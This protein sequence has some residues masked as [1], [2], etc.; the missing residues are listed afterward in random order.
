ML[1]YNILRYNLNMNFRLQNI[2]KKEKKTHFEEVLIRDNFYQTS[3][4]FPMPVTLI[5]TISDSGQTNIGAYSL[6]FPHIISGKHA[7]ILISRGSSNTAQNILKRKTVA[8][9]FIPDDKKYMRNCVEL[10]YPGESTE[11]KMKHSI[12]TLIPCFREAENEVFPQVVKEAIQI[13]ECR[14]DDSFPY[15]IN[16]AEY[17]FVLRIEKI[18]MQKE[19]KDALEEG[20]KF[21]PL[22]VDY[23]FREGIHFWF[24]DFNTPYAVDVP[25]HKQTDVER[26]VY[27]ANRIDPTVQWDWEACEKLKKV[28]RIFLQKVLKGIVAEAKKQ[29]RTQVTASFMD[30]L[31]ASKKNGK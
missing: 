26:I 1:F 20:G 16:E 4:F 12:F 3:S 13:F 31:N 22:P 23:G 17:H 8:I 19:W 24:S 11:E 18:I 14:W 21:P 10:G 29:G 28:P 9:N 6:C 5:S 2:F 15:K 7:M 27:L 25:N 30:E